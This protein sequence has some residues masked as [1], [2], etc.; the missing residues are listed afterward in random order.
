MP[1]ADGIAGPYNATYDSSTV[2]QT[3]RGFEIRLRAEKQL[4]NQT[5][6]YGD[7][8]IDAVYR[9]GNC[10]ISFV[11]NE[12]NKMNAKGLIWPYGP[13]GATTVAPRFGFLGTIGRMDSGSSLAKALVL[14]AVAGT[15]AAASPATLTSN[16][17]IL[18]EGA[19][20]AFMMAPMVR[21]VPL[22]LRAYPY[23]VTGPAGMAT[24]T[25]EVFFIQT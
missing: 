18:A 2:G 8:I 14:T 1:I 3:D 13:N 12:W 5:H 19:D 21:T 17:T 10:L 23:T 16:Q 11:C 6:L 4:Y 24:G 22:V 20:V 25:Y 7:T 15:T 9:G